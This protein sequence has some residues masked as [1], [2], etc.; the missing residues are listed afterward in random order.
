MRAYYSI[1][2]GCLIVLTSLARTDRVSRRGEQTS[3]GD[4]SSPS[5]AISA[6]LVQGDGG[7]AHV[8][9]LEHCYKNLQTSM[10]SFTACVLCSARN[11]ALK[12]H[13]LELS[14]K[15]I[16]STTSALSTGITAGTSTTGNKKAFDDI[17]EKSVWGAQGGGSGIGSDPGF[18]VVAGHIMRLAVYKYGV[19]SLLDAPCGGVS[20]SWTKDMISQIKSDLNC[21]TYHG[22]DVVASV[23]EKN[24]KKFAEH[25]WVRFSTMDLSAV[26]TVLPSGYDLLL[27]RDALQHLSYK[28]VAGAIRTYW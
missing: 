4:A 26:E 15:Q 27:S 3:D 23:I 18:A 11:M 7:L 9:V 21:F 2:I 14:P 28:G 24:Q 6:S 10:T 16:N 20:D 13:Q 12:R 25:D 5:S 1:L 17:Y 22:V 19:T 8:A